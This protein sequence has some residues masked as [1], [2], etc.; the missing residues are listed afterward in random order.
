MIV[1]KEIDK[2]F[3]ENLEKIQL[4]DF[5]LFSKHPHNPFYY[6]KDHVMPIVRMITDRIPQ[7]N[8]VYASFLF[9]SAHKRFFQEV[10]DL[11]NKY[12]GKIFSDEYVINA[13]LTKYAVRYDI[14]YNYLPNGSESII[15]QYL[16]NEENCEELKK[17]YINNNCQVKFYIFHGYKCKDV[18][19]SKEL[20]LK[21]RDKK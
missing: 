6:N 15:N 3:E 19:Y 7:M 9:S 18:K 21:L 16:N 8:Y 1:T 11:M 12:E 4:S 14:G 10:L 20:I 17:I 13:L 2:I 5:P